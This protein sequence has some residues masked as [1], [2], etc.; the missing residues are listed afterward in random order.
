MAGVM[1]GFAGLCESVIQTM[2]HEPA[3]ASVRRE[4]P[5]GEPGFPPRFT[6][7]GEARLAPTSKEQMAGVKPGFAGLCE[8]VIQTVLHEPARASVRREGPRGEPG[9]PPRSTTPF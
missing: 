8:S 4:G 3:R 1:P 5:R 2:L 9:F 7:A 6:T